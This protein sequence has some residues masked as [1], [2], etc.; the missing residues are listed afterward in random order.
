MC[1]R[2]VGTVA[3]VL[4][5]YGLSTVMISLVRGTTERLRPPR[6]LHC[7]FPLGRPLGRPRDPAFQRNVLDAA[8][9]LLARSEGPVLEDFHEQ[10]ED[11]ADTPVA[12]TVP[13]RTSTGHHAAAEE[14][15]AYRPAYERRLARSGR[16]L[17]GRVIGPEDVPEA[18]EQFVTLAEA[19]RWEPRLLPGTPAEV[20]MDVRAYYEEAALEL[21]ATV[22]AARSVEAWFFRETLTGR[23]L[24]AVQSALQAQGEPR[25]V[26][27][28]VAPRGYS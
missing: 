26:W 28:G 9:A 14:A 27:L 6:A 11:E 17:V 13:P 1:T 8:F 5:A 16:T 19:R 12:C 15:L 4:E 7:E 24:L 3:H 21:S 20:A 18:V 25:D 23:L 10:I 22:P 2:T